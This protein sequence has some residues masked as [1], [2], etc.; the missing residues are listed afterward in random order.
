M[1]SLDVFNARCYMLPSYY[2]FTSF[3]HSTHIY[4]MLVLC[5]GLC[6]ALAIQRGPG[7][8][9]VSLSEF[10]SRLWADLIYQASQPRGEL[11]QL[12]SAPTRKQRC[13]YPPPW[14]RA[15]AGV[16]RARFVSSSLSLYLPQITPIL[17]G[18]L[19][20]WKGWQSR[21]K[22]GGVGQ[23]TPQLWV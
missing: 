7:Q 6:G 17:K 8:R 16:V 13:N 22:R 10:T 12:R 5:Q 3:I 4:R 21:D 19:E 14:C 18:C 20:Q 9:P 11:C 23:I 15:P 1:N 2:V